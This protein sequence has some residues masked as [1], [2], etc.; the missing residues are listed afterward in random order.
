MFTEAQPLAVLICAWNGCLTSDLEWRTVGM[1]KRNEVHPR[2][3][4]EMDRRKEEGLP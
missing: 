2:L 1:G 3:C 4:R